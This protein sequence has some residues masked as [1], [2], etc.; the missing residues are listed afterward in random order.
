MG[1]FI[2]LFGTLLVCA[3]VLAAFAQPVAEFEDGNYSPDL[4]FVMMFA[5]I[6]NNCKL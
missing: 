2:Y 6:A 5:R 1:N 4:T 3:A